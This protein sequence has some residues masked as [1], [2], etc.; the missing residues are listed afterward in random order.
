[1]SETYK[2]LVGRVGT[3]V[4][5]KTTTTGKQLA[6]FRLAVDGA[7]DPATK[8]R[9]TEWYDVTV[10]EPMHML[11]VNEFSVGSRVWIAGDTSVFHGTSGDR[12]KIKAR[13]LGHVVKLS[14]A[15]VTAKVA[16]PI[17]PIPAGVEFDSEEGDW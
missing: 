4:L 9:A 6:E 12:N 13:E 1:M 16:A 10:W 17:A 8:S 7:Y 5:V 3:D 15:T 2:H 14:A 11:A